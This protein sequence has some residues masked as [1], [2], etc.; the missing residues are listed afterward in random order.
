VSTPRIIHQIWTGHNPIP[1]NLKEHM[2]SWKKVHP[3]WEYKLWLPEDLDN[4]H[5]QNQSLYN[6]ARD[7][8]P[9]DWLRWRAD[10]ARLEILNQ[11][12]GVY[13]DTD[14]HCLKPFDELLDAEGAWFAE[15]PNLLGHA[16]NAVCAGPPSD[17]AFETLLTEMRFNA[18]KFPS[19]TRIHERVGPAYTDRVLQR[20]PHLAAIMPWYYFAGQSIK[21]RDAGKP[22]DLSRAFC[23]HVYDNT[24]R[25]QAKNQVAA[26]KFAAD[27]LTSVG[28]P[29]VL[30]FGMVLGHIREGRILPWDM[31]IDLT[32]W[33]EDVA[34]V[35][36]AFQARGCKFT[37][38]RAS[39][40]W[41]YHSGI[42]IDLHTFYE[43]TENN[44]IYHLLGKGEKYTAAFPAYLFDNMTRSVF[45]SRDVWL[46]SP[47]EE[48]IEYNYGPDWRTPIKEWRWDIDTRAIVK[49]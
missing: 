32:I 47:A 24:T 37:R 33:P 42:K 28:V 10:I 5:M 17:V 12:G 27:T 43:N 38:D 9:E 40:M 16:T 31:D 6:A 30:T 26:F 22:V 21:E 7:E 2:A 49:D 19:G 48:Y 39:Q 29:V 8:A 25:H 34:L 46:P 3:N 35:R 13:A 20:E 44:T 41:P 11:F 14:T 45:Y 1:Y 23:H 36:R 15:S 4:L 18:A